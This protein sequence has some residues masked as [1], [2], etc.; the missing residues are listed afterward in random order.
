MHSTSYGIF[1]LD[2]GDV[3]DTIIKEG[4]GETESEGERP[5]P[6]KVK[7]KTIARPK[8]GQTAGVNPTPAARTTPARQPPASPTPI[9]IDTDTE[10]HSAFSVILKKEAALKILGTKLSAKEAEVNRR[11]AALIYAE[12][13]AAGNYIS[14]TAV[15]ESAKVIDAEKKAE[16]LQLA[17]NHATLELVDMR[18]R[19]KMAR[20]ELASARSLP[21]FL[22]RLEGATGKLESLYRHFGVE[23]MEEIG[24]MAMPGGRMQ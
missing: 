7:T 14:G 13:G 2:R 20:E 5:G 21:F 8:A 9:V 3:S 4:E 1:L 22:E 16:D 24:R 18:K 11:T 23:P 10:L 6:S 19:L 15:L 12:K 17:L